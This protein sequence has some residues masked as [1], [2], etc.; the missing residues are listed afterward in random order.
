MATRTSKSRGLDL[1]V[2]RARLAGKSGLWD[3]G[4]RGATITAIER[5]IPDDARQV[6]EAEGR[7]AAPT[8][9][10][11]HVHLDKCNLGD[12]MRPNKTNSFQECLEI[13]WEH[14]RTYTVEDI[15]ERASRAIEEGI[16]NGTTVFRVFADVDTIG[17]VRPLEGIIALREKWKGIVHIEAVNFPQEAIIR[18]PGTAKLMEQ[19]MKL[20]A[21][22]VGGLPW[23]EH[24][25]EDARTHV[26][27]CFDLA[28][29]YGKDIH[30][31]V[32]D[33][34][35]PNSRSLE[36]LAVKTIREGFQGRVSASHCGALASYDEVHAHKVM[37][38]VKEAG[39]SISSNPHISLVAQGRYDQEPIRRGI[40]RVKQMWRMGVNIFSSQDDVNDPYY[41]FGRNDQQEV[42]S[43]MCHGCHMTYPDEIQA[44]FGFVTDNAAKALRLKN[45]GLAVGCRADF[46]VLAAP[47]FRHVLRLQQPPR[48]VIGS[49]KILAENELRRALNRRP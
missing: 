25:D 4:V 14:K 35:N 33:I 48:Y 24:L 3:I 19:G 17:G 2:R 27:M 30:M 40:T 32:D 15:V 7:L 10:N 31:L 41:P 5:R 11:G 29:K 22:V 46:N 44:V 1:V 12:V 34:D 16:L 47:T 20:G 49:G 26:D 43:F 39:I 6:I 28:K 45:Y 9:V 21:D 8:Y 13:T 38:L 36:Y 18:D 23:H 42:A 37:A